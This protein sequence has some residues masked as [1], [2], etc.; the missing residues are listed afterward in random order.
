MYSRLN[1]QNTK[2]R[3]A[4]F[5]IGYPKGT[6]GSS[7]GGVIILPLGMLVQDDVVFFIDEKAAFHAKVSHCLESGCYA[8][9]VLP[10]QVI[11]KMKKGNEAAL[12]FKATNGKYIMVKMSLAGFTKTLKELTKG[13]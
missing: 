11:S 5:A 7:A 2:K 1:L 9:T 8:Q 3:V 4:E 12:K 6:P 13:M 10:D